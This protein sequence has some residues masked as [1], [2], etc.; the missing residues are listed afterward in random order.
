MVVTTKKACVWTINHHFFGRHSTTKCYEWN[1]KWVLFMFLFGYI[2][3]QKVGLK[4][5][6]QY[7]MSLLLYWST[8]GFQQYFTG[9]CVMCSNLFCFSYF[10]LKRYNLLLKENRWHSYQ[11]LSRRGLKVWNLRMPE[12]MA[13]DTISTL[14]TW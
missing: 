1:T 4:K 14:C 8:V 11:E 9:G 2:R 3:Y 13:G 5:I 12:C 7:Q 10:P 6:I